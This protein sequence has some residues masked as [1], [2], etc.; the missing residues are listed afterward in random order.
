[1]GRR[2]HNLLGAGRGLGRGRDRFAR[3]LDRND[4]APTGK[5]AFKMLAHFLGRRSILGA[6][7][8]EADEKK[9]R[10]G[11]HREMLKSG[12]GFAR[13]EPRGGRALAD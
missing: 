7:A 9:D 1:M 10:E 11:L 3:L 2:F 5:A 13:A 12:A 8:Q 6:S 4:V